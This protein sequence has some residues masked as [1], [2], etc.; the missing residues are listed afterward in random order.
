[1]K[2]IIL[3]SMLGGALLISTQ[4]FA[5]SD[6]SVIATECRNDAIEMG[7]SGKGFGQFVKEC[8]TKRNLK[9]KQ[10]SLDDPTDPFQE[11]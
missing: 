8:A 7:L 11:Q 4:A 3:M 10:G 9:V 5:E 1:M 6:A 2:K